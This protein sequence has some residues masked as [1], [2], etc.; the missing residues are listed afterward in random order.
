[1]AR[2]R[3]QQKQKIGVDR[4]VENFKKEAPDPEKTQPISKGRRKDRQGKVVGAEE[5][6]NTNQPRVITPEN[7]DESP[8]SVPVDGNSGDRVGNIDMTGGSNSLEENG[9]PVSGHI[10]PEYATS[11]G[12]SRNETI[13]ENMLDNLESSEIIKRLRAS[14]LS[15]VKIAS[16][17]LGKQKPF[18]STITRS[19]SNTTCY[20]QEKFMCAYPIILR[21][22]VQFGEILLLLMVVWLDSALRGVDSF[23]HLG[24]TAFLSVIWCTAFSAIAMIG[25][26]KFSMALVIIAF[27]GLFVGFSIG[28]I[29]LAICGIVLLWVYGSFWTTGLVVCSGGFAYAL[30]HEKLALLIITMY[31]TYCGRAYAGWLGLVLAL[32]LSFISSDALSY[33]VRN[34]V[35]SE[36]MP[37]QTPDQT[38]GDTEPSSSQ[39]S[40]FPAADRS[41]G[42]PSTSGMDSEMTSDDEVV[43]LL[44]CADHYSA[45]GMSR[46]GDVD[47][48]ILKREY[49]KKAM[50][51]HPDKNMGNEKAVEAFKKLQNAYEVLLDSVK[52]KAYDDELRREELLNFF[53]GIQN[54]SQGKG[55]HNIFGSGFARTDADDDEPFG[56]LKRIACRKCGNSHIWIHTKKTKLTARWCQDC[57]DFHQAKDGD[58]W[59]EQSSQPLLFGMLQKVDAPRA[60]V[61]ADSRVYDATEWY[62]CQGMRCPANT[63][64]PS[65]HVNTSLTQKHSSNG[66]GSGSTAQRGPFSPPDENMS[67]EQFFE[68]LR[69]A[70]QAG[71]FDGF[72]GP[73]SE[74]P[75]TRPPG[76]NSS[77]NSGS[78]GSSSKR[79]KKGKKPW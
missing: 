75:H 34:N 58:G 77:N 59:V 65:F 22:L 56:E 78:G 68:W 28:V 25:M 70:A 74:S 50:L 63:H 55:R 60:Y 9:T 64:K 11:V 73:S 39:T 51:V 8:Q 7:M 10:G 67:E 38:S 19:V 43:R 76:N 31:S 40:S 42:V 21:R 72:G 79:K 66:K 15:V 69:N 57:K 53:R 52:R 48:S 46:H 14:A 26:F 44:N 5:I 71:M 17:I 36:S 12:R 16:E 32:N 54:S 41:S 2:K 33:F 3:S 45:L 35:N 18:F 49:R 62:I 24:T 20:I 4:N 6:P 27:V 37:R 61:C 29:L 30:R 13:T 1:M 23:L 47:V